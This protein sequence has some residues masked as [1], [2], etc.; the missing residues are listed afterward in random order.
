MFSNSTI[1]K[2]SMPSSNVT[3]FAGTAGITGDADGVGEAAQFSYPHG[4]AVDKSGYVYVGDTFNGTIR[5]ITP[6]ASVSTYAGIATLHDTIDGVRSVARIDFP[7]GVA[8]AADAIV[9]FADKNSHT[10]RKISPVDYSANFD[11]D[12]MLNWQEILAGTDPEQT[13][14]LLQLSSASNS[15]SGFTIQWESV[16]GR[17]YSIQKS[18]NLLSVPVFSSLATN[19][20]GQPVVTTYT[21][22]NILDNVPCYYRIL[23]DE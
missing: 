8:V 14:S 16:G 21:D 13:L 6:A 11:G 22:T 20:L 23:L 12:T 2:I 10:V 5:R 3:T 18:T 17:L 15:V 4:V 7:Y 1:R 19:L 9:C